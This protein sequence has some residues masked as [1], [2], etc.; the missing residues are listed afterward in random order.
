MSP[1]PSGE[2]HP[3]HPA[4][5][6]SKSRLRERAFMKRLIRNFSL[7]LAE[8]LG[9]AHLPGGYEPRVG[10]RPAEECGVPHGSLSVTGIDFNYSCV[11]AAKNEFQ[12]RHRHD[13]NP[14]LVLQVRNES[15]LGPQGMPGAAPMAGGE[16]R[17]VYQEQPEL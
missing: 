8:A 5:L 4:M 14:W 17:G 7:G 3:L 13:V 16:A 2:D 9:S 11:D 6:G 15:L 12:I 10:Q 1:W